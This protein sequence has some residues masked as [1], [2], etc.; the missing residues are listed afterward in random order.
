MEKNNVIWFS[1]SRWQYMLRCRNLGKRAHM[2]NRANY[3]RY[4]FE[5]LETSEWLCAPYG[6]DYEQEDQKKRACKT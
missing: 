6:V 5:Q 2:N 4:L 1:K 3:L